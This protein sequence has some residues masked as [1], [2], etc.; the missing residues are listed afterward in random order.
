MSQT[1]LG[2]LYSVAERARVTGYLAS[3]WGISAVVGP[4]LGGVFS[5]YASWRWIFFINI[6]LGALA[7][8]LLMRGF[9]EKV[10]RSEHAVD[11]A[12]AAALAAG[13]SLLILAL[14]EGGQA[15]AWASAASVGVFG[16]GLVLLLVFVWVE[17]R[18]IEPMLPGWALSRRILAAGNL[19]SFAVGA[20]L[21]G[22]TTY[23]PTFVQTVLGTAPR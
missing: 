11:Y 4:T 9:K 8:W 6:P 21:F 20:L 5:D 15:W 10:A 3:V 1:I 13:C 16:V 23:V 12:G 17:R 18:A 7:I 22:L 19:V 2:D 14:L